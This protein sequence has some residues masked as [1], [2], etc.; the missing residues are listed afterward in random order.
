M[1]TSSQGLTFTFGGTT[2]TATSFQ[3]NDSTD[4]LDATHLG[5]P[6]TGRRVFQAAFA[7]EREITVEYLGT[8]LVTSGTSG[9]ISISGPVSF[10]GNA[11]CQSSSVSGS[12]GALVTGNATFRVV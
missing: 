11:T 1:A 5:I 12:V 3:V 7:G 2:L 6:T 10:T 9:A 4:L 8:G